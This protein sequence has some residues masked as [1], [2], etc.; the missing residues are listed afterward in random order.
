MCVVDRIIL[1]IYMIV[2]VYQHDKQLLNILIYIVLD[3]IP[4]QLLTQ[5]QHLYQHQHIRH[6]H[7]LL[8]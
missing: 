2:H 5:R 6:Q 1:E 7:R 8:L 4:L 3:Q